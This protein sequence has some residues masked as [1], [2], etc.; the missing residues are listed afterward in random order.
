MPCDQAPALHPAHP[1]TR[2]ALADIRARFADTPLLALG[3]TIW[4]DEPMKAALRTLLDAEALGGHMVFGVHDTDYFAKAHTQIRGD[5]RFELLPHNDGGTRDLWS[6]A[7]EISKLFGSETVPSRHALTRHGVPFHRLARSEGSARQAFVDAST[8]AWGWRGLVQS[9]SADTV[10]NELRLRDVADAL[11]R[12]LAWGFDGTIEAIETPEVAEHARRAADHLLSVCR[13]CC[14]SNPD[15][16]LTDLY[17]HAYPA[18]LALIMG[19]SVSD[20]SVTSTSELLRFDPDTAAL[21][22]FSLVDLFLTPQ[23]RRIAADAYDQAVAGSEMYSLGKFGLGALPFDLVVPGRGRGTLRVTLRAVHVET[24][25]PIRIPLRGP[26]ASVGA[27]AETLS[28]ALGPDL[29][30]VGKAVTLISM[31]AREFIF[32]FS[33]AGSAYVHRTR[34]MHDLMRSRGVPVRVHPMLRLHYRTWD[35]AEGVPTVVALPAPFREPF[36]ADSAPLA[37][38]AHRWRSVVE[39]QEALLA[40][41]SSVRSPRALLA[42][43]NDRDSAGWS[44]RLRAHEALTDRILGARAAIEPI[45]EQINKLHAALDAVR[46]SIVTREAEKSAHFRS[47]QDW[48]E[49]QRSERARLSERVED[50]LRTRRAMLRERRSLQSRRRAAERHPD[51]E[52]LRARKSALELEAEKERLRIVRNALLVTVGLPHTDH[53][54]PAWWL[55]FVDPTG[56]W[57]AHIVE[58]TYAYVEPLETPDAP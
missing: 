6:A 46:R 18:L 35:S 51:L 41:I 28:D 36:G 42:F 17:R 34:K 24:R 43:L 15:A 29:V 45:A 58:T 53:R 12:M 37:D 52:S 11:K 57:F 7:G 19:R 20:Y 38:I 48:S 27:L 2:E 8:E 56:H 54:P 33:E 9:G 30:L 55:P 4:W 13:E 23:T 47:V 39:E 14:R 16:T 50:A 10:V 49:A 32:V 31:L 3:Q 21:P 40:A 1:T 44:D 26:I 5:H 25:E 22:R